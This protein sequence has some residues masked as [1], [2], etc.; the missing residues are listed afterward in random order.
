MCA[1]PWERVPHV[2]IWAE[3]GG[4]GLVISTGMCSG[5]DLILIQGVDVQS[6]G[7]ST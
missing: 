5:R 4:R 7:K 1:G 3:W 6:C 2:K